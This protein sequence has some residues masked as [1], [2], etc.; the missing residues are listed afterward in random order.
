MLSSRRAA[1]C[2][3]IFCLTLIAYGPALEGGFLWDDNAHATAP[4]LRSLDGLWRIW[5]ELGATQQYYPLLHSAFWF[6]HKLWGDAVVGYHL[7]NVLLHALAAC[8]L[9]AILRR[10][11]VPGAWLAGLLFAVH[12]VCVEAVAWIS[13]QKSTLSAVFYLAA[14]LAYL[15]FDETRRRKH[16]TLALGLFLAALLSKSVTATL[17]AALLLVFWWKRGKL[18]WKRDVLPLAPWFTIGIGAGLFT[19]WVERTIIGAAGAE[20]RISF[21]ERCLVAG[22]AFWFYLA[23][24]VWPADLVFLYPRWKVDGSAWWQ[25]MFPL[26]VLAFIAGL[27]YY[28]RRRRGPL[29]AV[30]FFAGTL[31]P[32]LGF[33]NVY[34]F[35]YSWV[36]DHFQ[37]LASIGILTLLAASLAQ[38]TR[39]YHYAG[40]G[41]VA[42]LA[43]LTWAQSATYRDAETLY[44]TTIERNPE[45]WL[46]HN[47]LG[48]DLLEY[49]GRVPE[50]LEHLET[51]VSLKPDYLPARNN[52]GSA[53]SR[54]GRTD[55]AVVQYEAILRIQPGSVN[56]HN[57][58]GNALAAAGRYEEAVREFQA[59]LATD[60][61]AAKVHNNLGSALS[62]LGRLP[63]AIHEFEAA[64]RLDP[65]YAEAQGNRGLAL[66]R[67]ERPDEAVTALREAV[68]MQPG[69]ASAHSQLGF[70]LLNLG[71]LPGAITEFESAMRLEPG[72]PMAHFNLAFALSRMPGRLEQAISEYRAAVAQAPDFADAHRNLGNALLRTGRPAEA[73][74]A[75]EQALQLRPGDNAVRQLLKQLRR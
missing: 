33:F 69:A 15:H 16:Y 43:A 28:A 12:P 45:C 9:V 49:A 37:Y 35:L 68:R 56:A 51:A 1:A 23:K 59:A 32:A 52:L 48:A 55:E 7:T 50:A 36:A 11:A 46:A 18:E 66:L 26:A 25:Y 61:G 6:E 70:A 64:L 29:A 17:P 14:A 31:F 71:Q 3:L 73:A 75:F 2:A 72:S 30:L 74:D 19:A 62:N 38:A 47:N 10:L 5:F 54:L 65:G 53:L 40:A 13:E 21:I 60:S 63:E 20:F 27:V 67:A 44:R 58:L 57:N 8:L 4:A 41:L 24:L 34:P 22:R 42:V 39:K